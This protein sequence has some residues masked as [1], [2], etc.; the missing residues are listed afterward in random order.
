MDLHLFQKDVA[1]QIGVRKCTIMN[2]ETQRTV[3]E[4]RYMPAII[5][6]LGYDPMPQPTAFAEK[7]SRKVDTQMRRDK[8]A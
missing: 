7:W 5:Q 1:R 4:I 8:P 3:P 2:W 6:F